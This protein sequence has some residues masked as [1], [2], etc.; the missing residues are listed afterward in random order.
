[1][2]SMRKRASYLKFH[3]DNSNQQ[4]LNLITQSFSRIDTLIAHVWLYVTPTRE[5][6]INTTRPLTFSLRSIYG[7]QQFWRSQQLTLFTRVPNVDSTNYTKT[8]A[9]QKNETLKHI[10]IAKRASHPIL[11]SYYGWNNLIDNTKSS[12][13]LRGIPRPCR[14]VLEFIL[15]CLD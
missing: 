15:D 9:T 13:F 7:I 10:L 8:M 2:K 5:I 14:K 3:T 6:L 1:M 4:T 11:H 12:L